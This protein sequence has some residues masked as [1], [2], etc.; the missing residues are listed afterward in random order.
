MEAALGGGRPAG[1]PDARRRERFVAADPGRRPGRTAGRVSPPWPMRFGPAVGA[2]I[3]QRVP[4]GQAAR[5]CSPALWAKGRRLAGMDRP[6]GHRRY[7]GPR[8]GHAAGRGRPSPAA[9]VQGPTPG[10]P[11][12]AVHG[13]RRKSHGPA[14]RVLS[15]NYLQ[16]ISHHQLLQFRTMAVGTQ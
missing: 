2:P 6:T 11:L 8:G 9:A 1:R 3:R 5:P 4:T 7:C 12:V 14:A 15:L 10:R 13:S 16:W